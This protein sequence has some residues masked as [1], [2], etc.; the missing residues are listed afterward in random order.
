[1]QVLKCWWPGAGSNHRHTDF[2]SAALPTELPGHL[3][4]EYSK[5]P[6]WVYIFATHMTLV[7]N[8]LNTIV[9]YYF[10]PQSLLLG[11]DSICLASS[12]IGGNSTFKSSILW[13]VYP[14]K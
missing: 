3:K 1:M 4:R 7:C 12:N 8:Q 14:L 9:F 10:A 6:K 5:E 2:Q 13:K 11:V